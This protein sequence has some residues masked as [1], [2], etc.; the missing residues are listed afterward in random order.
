MQQLTDSALKRELNRADRLGRWEYLRQNGIEHRAAKS[1]FIEW[2]GDLFD[3]KAVVYM[4]L[5]RLH[6]KVGSPRSVAR[7]LKAMGFVVR[8]PRHRP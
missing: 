2:E 6:P 8:G 7:R 5:D 4:A 1:Y 3:M